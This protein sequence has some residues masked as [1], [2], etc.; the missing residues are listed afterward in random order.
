MAVCVKVTFDADEACGVI[1]NPTVPVLPTASF[2]R[3]I[4][5]VGGSGG[6]GGAGWGGGVG[7]AAAYVSVK[8]QSVV[9]DVVVSVTSIVLPL[10]E[11]TYRPSHKTAVRCQ[12]AALVLPLAYS[13]IS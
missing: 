5:P 8:V 3:V 12:C 6:G 1:V 11:P 4:A 10:V 9:G 13:R 7:G 2:R